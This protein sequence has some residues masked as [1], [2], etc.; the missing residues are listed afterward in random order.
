M[1]EPRYDLY[2]NGMIEDL[3][4]VEAG[5]P[6]PPDAPQTVAEAQKNLE[7][8]N[9]RVQ[10]KISATTGAGEFVKNL[11][12]VASPVATAYHTEVPV[13]KEFPKCGSNYPKLDEIYEQVSKGLAAVSFGAR[14]IPVYGTV[15]SILVGVASIA[16]SALGQRHQDNASCVTTLALVPSCLKL[17]NL[18]IK[19]WVGQNQ[20]PTAN[21]LIENPKDDNWWGQKPFPRPLLFSDTS[22]NDPQALYSSRVRLLLRPLLL[23]EWMR[24]L[25]QIR[26]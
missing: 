8:F 5:G 11:Y 22:I 6:V 18:D 9:K 2:V 14:T 12:V 15:A 25:S 16:V 13:D 3:L 21:H 26:L 17:E 7:D 10:S 23:L 4:R 1:S 19:V 24:F 20:N